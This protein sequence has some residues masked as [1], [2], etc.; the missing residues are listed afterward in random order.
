MSPSGLSPSVE[1]YLKAIY[2]LAEQGKAAGTTDLARA[3][4]VQPASVSGMI[5][6]LASDGFL[7]HEPYRGVRLTGAGNREALKV[8]RRH[9]IIE[10]FLV[11]RLGFSWD[12]VHEEAERLEHAASDRLIERLAEALGHPETDPHGAPIPSRSGEVAATGYLRLCDA[13]AGSRVTVR[14]VDD[15]DPR[16]LRYFESVGLLPGV[17]VLVRSGGRQET[18]RRGKAPVT[19]SVEL[20]V[21]GREE[22][23]I[24]P[25]DAAKRLWVREGWG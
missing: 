4:S 12:D 17:G 21:S 10:S 3:L 7:T 2:S 18:G 1:D 19:G 14:S 8:L 13:E 24:V 11:E 22:A 16:R 15:D 23:V 5:R 9:R 25:A 6:R 20:T